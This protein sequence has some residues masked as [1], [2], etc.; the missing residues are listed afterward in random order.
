[1]FKSL[2]PFFTNSLVCAPKYNFG[3]NE[4]Q[5]KAR[6]KAV[7]SVAKI[8]KAMKMVAASKMRIDVQRLERGKNFGIRTVSSIFANETYLQKKN[9]NIAVKKTLLV[10]ITS[11]KGLCGGVNSGIVRE[12]KAIIAPNR[13][14]YKIFSVGEKGTT[15][16]LRPAKDLLVFAA[17]E[18]SSPMNYA[19]AA[20]LAHKINETAE[21][22]EKIQLVYNEFRSVISTVIRTVDVWPKKQFSQHFK[23]VTKYDVSEPDKE[24]TQQY[25]F[26]LY[27]GSAV[28]HALLQNAASEQSARMNA[29]ENASKN[30]KEILEKLTL[31]YNKVRQARITMEL[32]EV[33]SG[34]NAL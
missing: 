21:D 16:L 20:S 34:A 3:A 29:M 32:V 22:C 1:M 33:V 8:T 4:K 14:G 28:Y 27:L 10:P 30:A 2:K 15:G 9:V 17:T 19:T 23:H 26:E 6:I 25:Y 11:D 12:V 18:L 7:K 24:Y 13:S 5:I 31:L